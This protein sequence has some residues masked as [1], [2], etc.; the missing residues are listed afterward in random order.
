MTFLVQ[1][2]VAPVVVLVEEQAL[3]VVL[4]VLVAV[5]PEGMLLH[6]VAGAAA[7]VLTLVQAEPVDQE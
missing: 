6:P 7:A 4:L 5:E 3:E 1:R 2:L